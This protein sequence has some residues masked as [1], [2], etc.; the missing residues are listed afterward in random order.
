MPS[1][2]ELLE[3]RQ[4]DRLEVRMLLEA[5]SQQSRTWLLAHGDE[6]A[7]AAVVQDFNER[8]AKRQQGVPMA[9]LLGEREFYGLRFFTTPATLIPRPE[10]EL[11]VDWALGDWAS[12]GK[13]VLELGTGTGCIAIAL[14]K[15]RPEWKITAVDESMA[16][17]EVA[18]RNSQHH[19]TSSIRW[20]QSDWYEALE[21][22]E[23]FDLILSNPP[24]IS[25][26]DP[27]LAQG[28][29]RFEPPSALTDGADGLGAIRRIIAQAPERM[30]AGARIAIEHG[31]E[32]G[33]AVRRL[34]QEAGLANIETLSDLQERER[35]TVAQK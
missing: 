13:Q 25:A 4:L 14:Q 20:L 28:D 33:E 30:K 32:Q 15:H 19:H 12:S 7:P 23:T 2:N 34:M 35:I 3:I 29:L 5:A 17:L 18:Q 27:H 11:L 24:Y 16:A 21:A 26:D 8:V 6:P 31:F 22:G 1:W 10:T 9:Y